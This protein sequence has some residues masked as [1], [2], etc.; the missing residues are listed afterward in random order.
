MSIIDATYFRAELTV[1]NVSQPA[2]LDNLNSFI[3]KYE[4]KFLVQLLGADFAQDFIDGIA[5]VEP[6][7]RY[8]ELLDVIRNTTTK[9]SPIANYVYCKYQENLNT[10]SVGSGTAKPALEN[11]QQASNLSKNVRAWN[12]MVENVYQVKA[13][14]Y[15]NIEAYPEYDI[16]HPYAFQNYY[17]AIY[18]GRISNAPEIY[19]AK[20]TLD[21]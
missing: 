15:A 6:E 9:E 2:V 10:V 17:R 11:A 8:T 1:A 4:Q 21:F 18:D 16:E 14:L 19:L 12:E 20:N 3:T 5:E 13:Y 7:E